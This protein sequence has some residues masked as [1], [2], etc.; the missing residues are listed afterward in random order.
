MATQFTISGVIEGSDGSKSEFTMHPTVGSW[1]QWGDANREQ[2]GERV[3]FMDAMQRGLE[4]DTDY[5][6]QAPE[7]EEDDPDVPHV[8]HFSQLGGTYWCDT[9]NSPYCERA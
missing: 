7:E 5:Y 2:L 8:G 9:C 4:E 6:D 1:S 3:A